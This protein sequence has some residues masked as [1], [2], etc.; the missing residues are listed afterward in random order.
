MNRLSRCCPNKSVQAELVAFDVLHH[1]AGLVDAVSFQQL[2]AAC[3]Q[4]FEA[5]SFGIEGGEPFI[6]GEP[7]A[8]ADIEMDSV[9]GGLLLRYPLEVHARSDA[10][11]VLGRPS[12][13]LL[14][15]RQGSVEL[16]PGA[17]PLGNRRILVPQCDLP[18]LRDSTRIFTV[19]SDLHRF[20]L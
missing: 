9:L 20:C 8:G 6:A 15:R 19:E 18:E 12:A 14:F 3:T 16:I 13:A 4:S 2:K 1:L 7:G 10:V 17:E 11:R 5:S